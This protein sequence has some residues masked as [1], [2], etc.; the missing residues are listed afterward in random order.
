M[1]IFNVHVLNFGDNYKTGFVVNGA[2]SLLILYIISFFCLLNP[3]N[4][5][6]K[7]RAF[8]GSR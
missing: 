6:Y 2:S 8:S 7:S 4:V 5:L 3:H 1:G